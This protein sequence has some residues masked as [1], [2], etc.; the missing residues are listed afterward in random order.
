MGIGVFVTLSALVVAELWAPA[1]ASAECYD[2][3]A[4]Y[5]IWA[6]CD[7]KRKNFEGVNL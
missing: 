6:K 1:P 4:A 3:P 7:F 2:P 5:V